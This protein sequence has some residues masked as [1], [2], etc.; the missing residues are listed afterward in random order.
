MIGFDAGGI[1]NF[2]RYMGSTDKS[3]WVAESQDDVVGYVTTTI[4]KTSKF[5]VV[6]AEEPYVEIDD[7]Y[8]SPECR[9][10]SLGAELIEV[11]LD[12]ARA[13]GIHYATAFASSSRVADTMR[14]YENQGFEPWGIQFFRKI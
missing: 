7:L 11:V 5:A 4:Y 9:S 1:A 10:Q 2:A 3:I 8:V 6:P 14:F 12:F 13:R